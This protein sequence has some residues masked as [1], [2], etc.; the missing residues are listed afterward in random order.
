MGV[1]GRTAAGKTSLMLSLFRI[2]EPEL[3]SGILIDGVNIQA[4]PLQTLRS[5]V[6][7]IPQDPFMFSGTLRSNLDP[8]DIYSD[9]AVW[10]ALDRTH[11][12][13]DVLEKF[14]K[15]L[16]HEISERGENISVG[17]RQ[18]VC[19]ARALLRNSKIIIMDEATASVDSATDRKIQVTIREEFRHCTVL[20]IAHRLETI[21]DF[22]LVLVMENGLIAEAGSP[23]QLLG[24]SETTEGDSNRATPVPLEEGGKMG[25]FQGFVN[26]LGPERKAQF[27]HAARHRELMNLSVEE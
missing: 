18:M 11:L 5:S 20:T 19:I 8:F 4:V 26:E 13:Q 22:D 17:Q 1:V 23:L 3:G 21:A 12:K 27:V 7:I 16:L 25:I 2:I 9:E 24:L 6:T 14:P 15:K 10:E